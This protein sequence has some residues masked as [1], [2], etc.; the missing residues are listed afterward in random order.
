MTASIMLR[1][2]FELVRSN[3]TPEEYILQVE[4]L[5]QTCLHEIVPVGSALPLELFRETRIWRCQAWA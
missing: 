4:L 3:I 1:V 2:L 5:E